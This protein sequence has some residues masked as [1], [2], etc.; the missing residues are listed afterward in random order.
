[1]DE[2]SRRA[3]HHVVVRDGSVWWCRFCRRTWPYPAP[4]PSRSLCVP[5]AWGAEPASLLPKAYRPARG[6]PGPI[7]QQCAEPGCGA[8]KG[9]RCWDLRTRGR[10]GRRAPTKRRMSP[11]PVRRVPRGDT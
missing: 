5:R 4:V 6:G 2:A 8:G 3:D 7:D 11:H 1:M 9:E 10:T